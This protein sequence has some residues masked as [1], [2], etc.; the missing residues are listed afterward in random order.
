[1]KN[2]L[3][4]M[5]AVMTL[6][7]ASCKKDEPTEKT[8]T[9]ASLVGKWTVSELG[10]DA[11]NNNVVDAG[12]ISSASA[13]GISGFIEFKADKSFANS[14]TIGGTTSTSSGT[15]TFASNTI[16]T[17]SSTETKAVVINT[18]TANKLI[19]KSTTNTQ[20]QVYTK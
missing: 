11:N 9:N 4:A 12:E 13:A 18:L 1:M 16:T 8:E 20:W 10:N 17:V 15:Y 19:V 2:L 5:A 6:L 7:G 3:F 14:I